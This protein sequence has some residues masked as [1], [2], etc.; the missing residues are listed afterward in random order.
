VHV[1]LR[2]PPG[3]S[4]ETG[5]VTGELLARVAPK[6]KWEWFVCGPPPMMDAVE[7]GLHDAGVPLGR[8][9]AERFDLV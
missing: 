1:L 9:H 6:G 2:P 5:F 8:I 4:G 7:R 3:W